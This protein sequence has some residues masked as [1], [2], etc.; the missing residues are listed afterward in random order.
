MI[1]WSARSGWR[2]QR[3]PG[4]RSRQQPHSR[5]RVGSRGCMRGEG[6]RAHL[7]GGRGVRI[8]GRGSAC[9]V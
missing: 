9:S 1:L 6:G 5:I 2:G 7:G 4:E 3:G 8:G